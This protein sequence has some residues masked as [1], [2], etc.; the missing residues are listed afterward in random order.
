VLIVI[1]SRHI[2]LI[3]ARKVLEENFKPGYP[4]PA[5]CYSDELVKEIPGTVGI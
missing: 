1:H 2:L 3:I 5:G 4:T